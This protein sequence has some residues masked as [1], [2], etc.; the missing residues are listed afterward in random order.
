MDFLPGGRDVGA[1]LT[2]QAVGGGWIG[3]TQ[4]VCN[5]TGIYALSWARKAAAV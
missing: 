4:Q 5:L 1:Q 3:I 2:E